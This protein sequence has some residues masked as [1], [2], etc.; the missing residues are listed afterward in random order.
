MKL[1]PFFSIP[2]LLLLLAALLA[3]NHTLAFAQGPEWHIKKIAFEAFRRDLEGMHIDL[4]VVDGANAKPKRLA[5][6]TSPSWSPDGQTLAYCIHGANGE[7]QIMVSEGTTRRQ[8]TDL[9][10]GACP[11]VWSPNSKYIAFTATGGKSGTIWIVGADG[12]NP[13]AIIEGDVAG[14]SPDG[15]KLLF[16]R[17]D[18]KGR[19]NGWIAN[20]DG[21]NPQ[22]VFSDGSAIIGMA[23][24][25]DGKSVVYSSE[26]SGGKSDVFRV[27]VD[28]THLEKFGSGNYQA[29]FSPV[30]SPDGKWLVVDAIEKSEAFKFMLTDAGVKLRR[31]WFYGR[32]ASVVWER[33]DREQNSGPS[34]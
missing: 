21:S 12:A 32:H 1:A 10:E 16:R 26:R 5:E 23:W 8:L 7:L 28:G 9:K 2:A 30:L 31:E 18:A 20:T 33:P 3:V 17:K 14:W 15:T 25:P 22:M 11:P 4:Y 24:F 13:R 27:N 6:G 19:E 34:L 29:M